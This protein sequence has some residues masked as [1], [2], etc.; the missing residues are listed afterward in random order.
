MSRNAP[1]ADCQSRVHHGKTRFS[2]GVSAAG[3]GLVNTIILHQLPSMYLLS[4]FVGRP[5]ISPVGKTRWTFLSPDSQGTPPAGRLRNHFPSISL[6]HWWSLVSAS[7]L[8]GGILHIVFNMLAL[9]QISPLVIRGIWHPS[10]DNHLHAQRRCAGSWFSYLAGVN[11]TNRCVPPP[12]A[13]SSGATLYYGKTPRW[14][15]MGMP[16]TARWGRMGDRHLP[17]SAW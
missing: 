6:H 3:E 11:F 14:G 10:H 2:P 5:R 15:P 17:S 16:F 7:Y 13:V 8:H 12:C 9:R 4:L 1:T